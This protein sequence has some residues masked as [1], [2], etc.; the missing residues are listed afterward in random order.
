[1]SLPSYLEGRLSLPLI[2]APLFIV[3][4]PDLVIEQCKAGVMGAFPAL[5]ARP[6][7]MLDQWI[8]RITAELTAWKKA[9]P[10][11]PVAPFAVNQIVHRSNERL[12]HDVDICVKHKVPII[13]TSLQAPTVLEKPIHGY[14]GRIFHD[15]TNI[16]HAK[17]ALDEGA[18]GLILVCA[19]AGGHAGTL[20]PFALVAEVRQ[21][22]DGPVILS[23]AMATGSQILAAQAMGADLA[24][25]G[26][27]FIASKEA[28]AP[29]RYKQM[30]VESR[31]SDIV[32]TSLFSGV[33]GNYL[34]ASI[35]E[36]GL[37]PANLPEAD[38]S[39]MDFRSGGSVD[40]RTWRDI[41][42]AGQSSGV[43]RDVPSTAEIVDRLRTEY[44][45]AKNVLR[46]Q[47]KP[48]LAS[49]A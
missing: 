27:R 45:A 44:E 4:N 42:S 20:S 22:F 16:R 47:S 43:I 32:Y 30:V 35:A 19:G 9:H 39:K 36:A 3:S 29:D 40:R 34:S 2:G 37:D 23:G 5:N 26:T 46:T 48:F 10:R 25:F 14:G 13:I 17:K 41:W 6:P 1:M 24:Y 28:N 31:A 18:D 38:K 33:K 12:E 15:V 8:G 21:F 7:E 11:A 49:A